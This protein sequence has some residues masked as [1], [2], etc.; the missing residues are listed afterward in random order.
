MCLFLKLQVQLIELH[1]LEKLM[2]SLLLRIVLI[3]Y[4]GS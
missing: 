3:S 2:A 4:R 1:V